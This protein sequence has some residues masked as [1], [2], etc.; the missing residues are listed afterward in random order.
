LVRARS[1]ASVPKA[2]DA[3]FGCANLFGYRS[4]ALRASLNFLIL[5]LTLPANEKRNHTTFGGDLKKQAATGKKLKKPGAV[6]PGKQRKYDTSNRVFPRIRY[7]MHG[8]LQIRF[9]IN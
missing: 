3:G 5:D 9:H 1:F 6:S 2:T 7:F 4:I 8:A